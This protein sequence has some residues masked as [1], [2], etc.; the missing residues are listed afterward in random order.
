MIGGPLREVL[1][2]LVHANLV[3]AVAATG[4]AV[5]AS[6]I[7]AVPMDP[8]P[9]GFVFAA[10]FVV[11]TINR[12]TDGTAD[13]HNVPGR[14]AF[15]VRYGRILMIGCTVVYVV[16]AIATAIAKPWLLPLFALPPVL[17]LGYTSKWI[18]GTAV[19]KNGMVGLCWA[20]IPIGIGGVHGQLFSAS[21]WV[22]AIVIAVLLTVAAM[23]FDLKDI[24]GDCRVGTQ[25]VPVV[26]GPAKTKT[27]AI[28]GIVGVV[29][30]ILAGSLFITPRFLALG[31]YVGY[32]LL[33]IPFAN[34]DRGTFFYGL[35]IDGEHVLVAAVVLLVSCFRSVIP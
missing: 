9:I 17:A 28:L 19:R 15:I 10:V 16:V 5:T 8:L 31:M 23:L 4:V 34:V 11:Y 6:W 26:I 21:T 24:E 18:Q 30:V 22:L 12:F 35:V 3:I 27:L 20:A 33:V 2:V 14:A 25:T 13:R 1:L 7:L 32:F 29:P